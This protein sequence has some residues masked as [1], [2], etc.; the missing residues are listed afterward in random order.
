MMIAVQKF[1]I[2][3]YVNLKIHILKYYLKF[4][5]NYLLFD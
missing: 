4:D 5:Y 1:N 2:T 3:A